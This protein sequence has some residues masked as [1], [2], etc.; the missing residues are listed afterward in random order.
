MPAWK[1]LKQWEQVTWSW[2]HWAIK[3]LL[4]PLFYCASLILFI[5]I[6]LA[7]CSTGFHQTFQFGVW[8]SQLHC[9]VFQCCFQCI[10]E[11][12]LLSTTQ[13]S[14]CNKLIVENI[15]GKIVNQHPDMTSPLKFMLFQDCKKAY[16]FVFDSQLQCQTFVLPFDDVQKQV[17]KTY[18][19]LARCW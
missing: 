7:P 12:F 9:F 19:D 3:S 13:L 15:V 2:T 4:S 5:S 8:A 6:S 11:L 17:R 18:N 16:H 1:I 10:L 14:T